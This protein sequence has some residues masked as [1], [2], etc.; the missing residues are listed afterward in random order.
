MDFFVGLVDS[1]AV[2]D[3]LRVVFL[4]VVVFF[5]LA[6]EVPFRL[7]ARQPVRCRLVRPRGARAAFSLLFP[8]LLSE[9]SLDVSG[10]ENRSGNRG[11]LTGQRKRTVKAIITNGTDYP[12]RAKMVVIWGPSEGLPAQESQNA[13]EEH[14]LSPANSTASGVRLDGAGGTHRFALKNFFSISAAAS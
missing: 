10:K 6:T 11:K 8:G 12:D 1:F 3:F 9:G 2:V 5:V 7:H 14:W 4:A 13:G